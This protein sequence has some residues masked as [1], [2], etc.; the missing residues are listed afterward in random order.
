MSPVESRADVAPVSAIRSRFPALARLE[1]GLPVAYFDGPGGT[2][3]PQ[4]VANAVTRYL[5]QH[6]AN[7]H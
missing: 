3:V 7:T 6:N 2:Q 5:L 4:E 1:R